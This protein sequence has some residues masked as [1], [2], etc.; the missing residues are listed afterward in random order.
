MR[1]P[2]FSESELLQRVESLIR[3]RMPGDWRLEIRPRPETGEAADSRLFLAGPDG[4]RRELSLIAKP[5]IQPRQIR[6]LPAAPRGG[7]LLAT[8]YL[9]A[10]ARELLRDAGIN[11]CDLTGNL[12]LRSDRPALLLDKDGAARNP[13]P[14]EARDL[15]GLRGSRAARVVRGLCDF[16]APYS[17]SELA[18]RCQVSLATVSRVAR[19]L[20]AEA[21]LERKERGGILR[22]DWPALLRRWSED[23]RLLE[24][25]RAT[26]YL[27]PRGTRNF[28]GNLP[29][30][31]TFCALT[32]SL[33]ASR[34]VQAAPARL[35][36]AYTRTPSR[37][38]GRL[39][40]TETDAGA[41]VVLLEP[42][43][44]VVFD[45][46]TTDEDGLTFVAP[47]QIAVDLLTSP[48]RGPSEAEV[49]LAWMQRNED[50]WRQT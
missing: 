47:S 16:R 32:G 27:D 18:S 33:A 14:E 3:S 39:D 43:D 2:D 24:T 17:L 12:W 7:L 21:L 23:Y 38:A 40:L 25:N 42:F 46:T 28:T 35:A 41:N 8:S 26:G 50:D 6:A 4:S 49:L 13:W 10:R 31:D 29:R 9:N 1:K 22:V 20:E 11:Y 30:S 5:S 48:G 15:K 44:P 45:R 36:V 37:L 34:Y 19:Y